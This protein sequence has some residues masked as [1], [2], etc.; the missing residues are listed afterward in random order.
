[1]VPELD[2]LEVCVLRYLCRSICPDLRWESFPSRTARGGVFGP[3]DSGL[4]VLDWDGSFAG[5]RYGSREV[6]FQ[7][8]EFSGQNCGGW[9]HFRIAKES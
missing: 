3:S 7:V 1:M 2:R 4:E 9:R 5:D 6:V 8:S